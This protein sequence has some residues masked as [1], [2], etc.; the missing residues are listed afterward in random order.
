MA[1]T[2]QQRQGKLPCSDDAVPISKQL[3]VT[4]IGSIFSNIEAAENADQIR[5]YIQT[6]AGISRSV[7][8]RLGREL[9]RIIPLFMAYC[10]D[11]KYQVRECE[12]RASTLGG[13]RRM[14]FPPS[15][16]WLRGFGFFFD[17]ATLDCA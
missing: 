14:P 4:L 7:G 13:T 2:C 6:I 10:E 17:R 15:F 5:T 8:H 11:P 1:A 12:G 16:H 9:K 3:F